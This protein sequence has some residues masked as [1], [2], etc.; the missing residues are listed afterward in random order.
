[1]LLKQGFHYCIPADSELKKKPET[2]KAG[3]WG[4]F[5]QVKVYRY[6]LKTA[7]LWLHPVSTT[8]TYIYIYIYTH[9]YTLFPSISPQ[10]TDNQ[11][12]KR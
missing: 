9:I 3:F 1:M 6:D 8:F 7:R 10:P 4:F 12:T 2:A 5:L 11:K